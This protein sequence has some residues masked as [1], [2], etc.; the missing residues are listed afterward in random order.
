MG[1]RPPDRGRSASCPVG[2]ADAS[3]DEHRPRGRRAGRAA[4]WPPRP[5]GRARARGRGRRRGRRRARTPRRPGSRDVEVAAQHAGASPAHAQQR[6]RAP[7]RCPPAARCGECT[8]AW[9]LRAPQPG[10]Q[11][12]GVHDAALGQQPQRVARGARRSRWPRTRIALAPPPLDLMRSGRRRRSQRRSG[13]RQLRE[14]SAVARVAR[15]SRGR[16]PAATTAGPPAAARRPSPSRRARAA[17]SS[18]QVAPGRRHGAAVEEVPGQDPHGRAQ[19]TAPACRAT[20]SP[21]PS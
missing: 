1:C 20:S 3:S 11:A 19:Y 7:A 21:A 15:R 13:S 4:A 5:T 17:N 8:C 12:H 6:R 18:Q 9:R 14:V 2:A 10:R 16:A